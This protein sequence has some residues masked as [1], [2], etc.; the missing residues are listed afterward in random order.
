MKTKSILFVCPYPFGKAPS[1]RLK[2]EQYFD[3]FSSCGYTVEHSSFQSLAMWDAVYKN[4]NLFSKIIYTIQGYIA[5]FFLLFK[6]PFYDLVYIHLWVTPFG[7]PVF[8][9]L[10]RKFSKKVIY[11]ID[12]LIF[13]ENASEANSWVSKI[14]GKKKPILLMKTANA[15]I[16]TTPFL[17]DYCH[18]WNGNVYA[19]P[20][21]LDEKK[22]FPIEKSGNKKLTIGWLGSHST[23][24]YLDIVRPALLEFAKAVDYQLV[25]MGAK[26]FAIDNVETIRY[27]W[28]ANR[29]NE[30]LNEI[31]IALYPLRDEVWSQGK[32]GGKLIQYFAAGLPTIVSDVNDSN[33]MV[34][35]QKEN[36]ILVKNTT[37]DWLDA[38]RLLAKDE[39]LR[40]KIGEQARLD[41][42]ENYSN[43]ANQDKYLNILNSVIAN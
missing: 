40:R 29:E 6:L 41:F 14:K 2:F 42:E 33:R 22:Y 26:D 15:I 20:P 9:W 25:L 10:Y 32:F 35:S 5:R 3:Y 36:G 43:K 30:V 31:D 8:E 18:Q 39:Q 13:M 11:D 19:I 37:E 38:L 28:K 34:I 27:E 24:A 7:F 1:Q 17:V 16:T 23:E 4:G 12:D 21:S